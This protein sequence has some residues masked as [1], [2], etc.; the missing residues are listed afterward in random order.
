[1]KINK[2]I[3]KILILFIA[4]I[5]LAGCGGKSRVIKNFT[6][7]LNKDIR[8]RI[9]ENEKQLDWFKDNNFL[10]AATVS[11]Y[12]DDMSAA[13]SALKNEI[14]TFDTES[15]T[16]EVED[17]I[18]MNG[19]SSSILNAMQEV[20][21][22][23]SHPIAKTLG[24]DRNDGNLV[25]ADYVEVIDKNGK[26]SYFTASHLLRENHTYHNKSADNI[27]M[28]N[29]LMNGIDTAMYKRAVSGA[30]DNDLKNL[31]KKV[32]DIRNNVKYNSLF[33]KDTGK[34]TDDD[35][36][37]YYKLRNG[38][39]NDRAFKI[40]SQEIEDEIKDKFNYPI[41]VLRPMNEDLAY[42]EGYLSNIQSL[43][44]DIQAGKKV[45]K[46]QIEK[47]FQPLY[48]D[49]GE[50]QT[51]LRIIN[52]Q[53]G[54]RDP[55]I[56]KY[57]DPVDMTYGMTA[58]SYT[59]VIG[60]DLIVFQKFPTPDDPDGSN[61]KSM[62]IF[63]MRFLEFDLETCELIAKCLGIQN[64]QNKYVFTST[65]DGD[66]VLLLEYPVYYIS[67]LS[68]GGA[69]GSNLPE[70]YAQ[71][72][73]LAVS[74]SGFASA[75]ESDKNRITS[76]FND[77][78]NVKVSIDKS[79]L[80]INLATGQVYKNTVTSSSGSTP[81][82]IT[83]SDAVQPVA[84][85]GADKDNYLT[86]NNS[87]GKENSSF[88]LLGNHKLDFFMSYENNK[89]SISGYGPAIILRDYIEATYAPDLVQGEN[90]VAFGRKFRLNNIQTIGCITYSKTAYARKR[91]EEI[92]NQLDHL[93]AQASQASG[94]V[95][96]A[97]E[98]EKAK[99]ENSKDNPLYYKKSYR[100]EYFISNESPLGTFV[101]IK[102]NKTTDANIYVKDLCHFSA[103][104]N[105]SINAVRKLKFYTVD[106]P[107]T[108]ENAE[109]KGIEDLATEHEFSIRPT[110]KF[111]NDNYNGKIAHVDV[112]NE[113]ASREV[114]YAI[115][116]SKGIFNSGLFATWINATNGD[117]C[118][119]WWNNY[120]LD[121]GF[122]YQVGH[123]DIN[124]YVRGRYAYELGQSGVTVLD[125]EV[126]GHIQDE[127]NE[128][129]DAART[130]FVRTLFI[131]FGFF[132]VLYSVVLALVWILDTNFDIG[133]KLLTKLTFGQ[134]IAVKTAY[135]IP[136]KEE[137]VRYVDSK[138]L[139]SSV[140]GLMAIGIILMNIDII[141]I[142]AVLVKIYGG[143]LDTL[144]K[145][146]KN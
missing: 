114:M 124:T 88:I 80:T 92:K 23:G 56:I 95:I 132:L 63:R 33:I 58:S 93:H 102:G 31:T 64:T 22:Y 36:I 139:V 90:V 29:L 68:T 101:D 65:G 3:S 46:T 109:I 50:V 77:K 136:T 5:M 94:A 79:C 99:I 35:E 76:Y 75:E 131:I 127:F 144:A 130:R 141:R 108:P 82:S 15:S 51:F 11:K 85:Y 8:S 61:S 47:Y 125:L 137:D 10:S 128:K 142:V 24:I 98:Q 106:D 143:I 105:T 120:L 28:S 104:S 17:D 110:C 67:G 7:T 78:N 21:I 117:A 140:I 14:L 123:T 34:S 52:S 42:V 83:S 32:N 45:T 39:S 19:L 55:K 57:S 20:V 13:R 138:A 41:Y 100:S 54:I 135:D 129:A 118:L 121:H 97:L 4:S 30:S 119:D 25:Y 16:A 126:I 6:V 2:H 112:N 69:N 37:Q 134:W 111:P 1:M 62:P 84:I 26:T 72:T 40:I 122:Q 49:N 70:F 116:T 73:Q 48:D 87:G 81:T 86:F 74:L 66:A 71:N 9:A 43:V 59:P 53:T 91:L 38:D 133:F 44:S 103:L 145:M 18:V 115:S 96:A 60:K 89:Y 12:K 107:D 27:L 146:F 113:T